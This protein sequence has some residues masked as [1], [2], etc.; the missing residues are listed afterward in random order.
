MTILNAYTV[1]ISGLL[2]SDPDKPVTFSL[3]TAFP[4][5]TVTENCSVSLAHYSQPT[6]PMTHTAQMEYFRKGK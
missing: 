3:F 6:W 1:N 5:K 4:S 2:T